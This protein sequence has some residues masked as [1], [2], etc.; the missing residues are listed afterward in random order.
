MWRFRGDDRAARDVIQLQV[1]ST[2]VV[3]RLMN[4]ST[5]ALNAAPSRLYTT[6]LHS[7][8]SEPLEWAF[9]LDGKV[10]TLDKPTKLRILCS[11]DTPAAPACSPRSLQSSQ[12]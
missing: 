10:G 5:E 8:V 1:V 7:C 11:A 2:V 12:G 9:R 3:F 4:G 6:P